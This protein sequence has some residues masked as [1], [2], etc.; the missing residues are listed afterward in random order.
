[1]DNISYSSS[2]VDPQNQVVLTASRTEISSG[3][4]PHPDLMKG[5]DIIV[6]DG[7]ERI[8]K[9][10]EM[11]QDNRFR[12]RKE[13]RETNKTIAL[14]KLKY[15]RRGQKMGFSLALILLALATVFVFT[16]HDGMAYLLFSV[17]GV[18]MVAQFLR[19]QK[20]SSVSN[21]E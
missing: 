18:S 21:P 15:M 6:K 11:Q 20:D 9:M 17:G 1:M 13:I 19:S 10:A 16:G 2:S 3:P 8:M 4:L 5:Y 7:A 14:E 12:E